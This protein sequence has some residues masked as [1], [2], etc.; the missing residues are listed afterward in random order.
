[1]IDPHLGHLLTVEELAPAGRREPKSRCAL[2]VAALVHQLP[3]CGR[4]R[5]RRR[6]SNQETLATTGGEGTRC[7]NSP[8]RSSFR[9]GRCR[10]SAAFPG[11]RPSAA[12]PGRRPRRH[13]EAAPSPLSLLA[14]P[15][16]NASY[17]S[18]V[19]I[20][21]WVGFGVGMGRDGPG[22]YSKIPGK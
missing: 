3:V 8:E 14:L 4:L 15:R 1:M 5:R 17:G 10:P 2:T 16:R 13:F 19:R 12:F 21:E 7:A 9:S 18:R 20:P 11:R 6:R 22:K